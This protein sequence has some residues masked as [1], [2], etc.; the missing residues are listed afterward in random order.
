[1]SLLT[2][3]IDDEEAIEGKEYAHQVNPMIIQEPK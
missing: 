2:H 1:M 3:P